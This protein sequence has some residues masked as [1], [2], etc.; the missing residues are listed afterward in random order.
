[1][2]LIH[3]LKLTEGEAVLKCYITDSNG[4]TIDINLSTWLTRPNEVY[5]PLTSKAF[6]KGIYWGVKSNKNIDLTRIISPTEVHGHYY[7]T[8]TGFY[9]YAGFVDNVYSEKDIRIISDGAFHVTLVLTKT[10]WK[11]KIEEWQFGSYDD[12]NVVG[13]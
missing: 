10:G 9:D 7:L 5:D 12:P 6:I 3:V 2:A 1:M 11:N 13:A 4:G 8:N